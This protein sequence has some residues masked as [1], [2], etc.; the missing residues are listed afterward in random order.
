VLFKPIVSVRFDVVTSPI[1]PSR[2]L[3]R[4]SDLVAL[5]GADIARTLPIGR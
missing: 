2:H 1:G 5:G 3:T 4:R